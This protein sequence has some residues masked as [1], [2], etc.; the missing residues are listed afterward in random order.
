[1]II[2]HP[3][4]AKLPE[5][6]H[7]YPTLPN[8]ATDPSTSDDHHFPSTNA[9]PS[10]ADST[11]LPPAY[12][13]SSQLPFLNTRPRKL[14]R[15]KKRL[16]LMAAGVLFI[17]IALTTTLLILFWVRQASFRAVSWILMCGLYFR[18]GT[19]SKSIKQCGCR[20]PASSTTQ[21]CYPQATN[22]QAHQTRMLV[23]LRFSDP[24]TD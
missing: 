8:L 4:D 12:A 11:D 16:R 21:S 3:P 6:L 20:A 10:I 1:M 23:T 2:T 24:T 18:L 19:L 13:D 15:R 22:L 14:L 17:Y 7:S 9:A 5:H